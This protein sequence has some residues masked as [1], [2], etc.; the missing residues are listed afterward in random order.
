MR[1]RLKAR[2]LQRLAFVR[3][4]QVEPVEIEAAPR[5]RIQGDEL[6]RGPGQ[7]SELTEHR[8]VQDALGVVG[9][10][11]GVAVRQRRPDQGGQTIEWH[12]VGG[13]GGLPV[14][15]AELLLPH[16][17]AGLDDGRGIPRG[18]NRINA[19]LP[20]EL[21][22]APAA[23]VVPEAAHHRAARAEGGEVQGDVGGAPRGP[24]VTRDVDHR[25]RRLRGDAGGVA[26]DVVVEHHIADHEDA[27][28]LQAPEEL[29][30]IA[31]RVRI[32]SRRSSGRAGA[33]RPG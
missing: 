5:L 17:H 32:A 21:R 33:G 2:E 6:A 3:R 25:H 26:P 11:H 31:H 16:Q 23:L 8:V 30:Q 10:D 29:G 1:G 13:R 19:A 7:A 24:G 4:D 20:Q 18:G 28:A 9:E 22:E 14:E 15:P 27:Q 12:L